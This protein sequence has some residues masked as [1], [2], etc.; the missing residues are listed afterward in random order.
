MTEEL[1]KEYQSKN[2]I[3]DFLSKTSVV[4]VI[5][6]GLFL[7]FLIK[8]GRSNIDPRYHYA[9]YLIFIAIIM[10]LYFKTEKQK[11]L[12]PRHIA[13]Q[14]AQEELE[15]MVRNGKE[16]PFDSKV[17]VMA[18]SQTKFKEDLI[19]GDSGPVAWAIGFYEMVHG[20]A[21]KRDG[22]V[23]IHPYEGNVTGIN[24]EPLGY[25]GKETKD[26]K[27]VPVGVVQGNFK[28]TDF[29]GKPEI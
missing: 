25:T 22:V 16:F 26:V 6:I 23:Y 28:T 24:W 12:I 2:K 10:V 29:S 18:A 27:I 11:K 3:A 13:A 7:F 21:F 20:T 19:K 5:L 15:A 14:I 8:I 4:H 17:Y 9:A 1:L